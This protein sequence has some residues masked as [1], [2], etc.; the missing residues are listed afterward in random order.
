M[1]VFYIYGTRAMRKIVPRDK[2]N[3]MENSKN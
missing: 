1:E 3:E 2:L